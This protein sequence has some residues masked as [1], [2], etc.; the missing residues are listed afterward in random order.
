M[1]I[2]LATLKTEITTDPSALGIVLTDNDTS[3]S[4]I[5]NLKRAAIQVS[6]GPTAI[7]Q[8]VEIIASNPTEFTALTDIKQRALSIL[9]SGGTINPDNADI[10]S[11]FADVFVGQTNTLAALSTFRTRDGSRIEELFAV[12]DTVHHSQIAEARLV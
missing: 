4:E 10:V 9:L 3:I 7:E 6:R 5:L 2:D 12:G 8:V 1:S 11:A